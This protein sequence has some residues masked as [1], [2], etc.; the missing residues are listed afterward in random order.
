MTI[1]VID[2]DKDFL[3]LLSKRISKQGHEVYTATNGISALSEMDHHK[4]DLVISDVVMRDTPIMSLT[5][6]LK[7]LYPAT[8]LILISGL[9]NEPVINNSLTLGAD[10]FIPKPI[11]MNTL[12]T[13]ID[14]FG[15]KGSA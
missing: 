6:T 15:R 10:E 8:P 1:L 14:K 13:T 11:N 12:F 5:C 9:P 4:I 2:D 3:Y 7:H